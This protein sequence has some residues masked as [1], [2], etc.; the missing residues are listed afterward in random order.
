MEA[1]KKRLIQGFNIEKFLEWQLS[2]YT[3]LPGPIQKEIKE[4]EKNM[5]A[6][7]NKFKKVTK[8]TRRKTGA[9][10]ITELSTEAK[11]AL[12]EHENRRNVERWGEILDEGSFIS[13]SKF[14][15]TGIEI[16]VSNLEGKL[17]T[18]I[19]Q[20]NLML[21]ARVKEA[22]ELIDFRAFEQYVK[23]SPILD[24]QY[25]TAFQTLIEVGVSKWAIE[26]LETKE[27]PQIKEDQAG[28]ENWKTDYI[29]YALHRLGVFELPEF[30][31]LTKEGQHKL[32][33]NLTG[34]SETNIRLSRSAIAHKTERHNPRKYSIDFEQWL[35]EHKNKP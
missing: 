19:V 30:K 15:L 3:E 26:I 35:R 6:E 22:F 17:K 27:E 1:E 25:L 16:E 13:L 31:T 5:L 28:S 32:I 33:S 7:W 8:S 29:I 12:A 9:T 20:Q 4:R 11:E 34:R 23:G 2:L 14:I 10:K 21:E 24:G 18:K